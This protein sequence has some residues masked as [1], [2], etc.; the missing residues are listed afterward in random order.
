[1]R[2]ITMN[3]ELYKHLE[4]YLIKHLPLERGFSDKT[5]ESYYTS[6]KQFLNFIAKNKN[7]TIREISLLD[8]TLEN[9]GDFLNHLEEVVGNS[10]TT[11]NLRLAGI[12]SFCKYVGDVEVKYINIS[13][14]LSKIRFK[15]SDSKKVEFLTVEEYQEL[16]KS[17]DL[18]EKIGLKHYVLINVLYDTGARVSELIN[19]SIE[20]INFGIENSIRIIGKGNKHR[21]VYINKHSVKLL[22]KYIERFNITSGCLF[23][24]NSNNKMTRFGVE[25]IIKKYHQ[26]ASVNIE[27]LKNKNVT[28]HTLRHTKACHFLINGTSLP[29][30]QRFLGHESITTTEIYLDV[31]SDVIIKAVEKAGD[32][33]FN[34]TNQNSKVWENEKNLIDKLNN[35]FKI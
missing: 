14:N 15:K 24:N 6:I 20:D 11:R 28:P 2:D 9:V 33:I 8:F 34:N 23:K 26:I 19:M 35:L 5:V 29:V 18:T 25:Y 30:I 32:L 22:K 21:L 12:V 1:M 3:K 13:N 10:V 16:I 4:M 31:T 27:S 7:K 17:V